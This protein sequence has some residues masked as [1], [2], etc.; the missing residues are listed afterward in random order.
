MKRFSIISISVFM[1]ALVICS[2]TT[3]FSDANAFL[4]DLN[5]IENGIYRGA[6]KLPNSPLSAT[7]DVTV[8]NHILTAIELVE[9]S[10]SPIGKKAEGIIERIIRKQSLDVDV[11]TGATSS[12]KTILKAVENALQ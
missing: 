7:V 4:P 9:H 1:F 2:C 8:Q 12:S 5:Y 3:K 11:V 10:C 6:Y